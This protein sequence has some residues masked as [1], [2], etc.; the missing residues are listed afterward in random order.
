MVYNWGSDVFIKG[1]Y[2]ISITDQAGN[3]LPG[4]M[5]Y[6][7]VGTCTSDGDHEVDPISV[8]F[9]STEMQCLL[10]HTLYLVV[11]YNPTS[12]SYLNIAV[13]HLT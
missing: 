10:V 2:K 1:F 6:A 5:K 13:Q 7:H 9:N 3:I 11:S 4:Q 8:H 12:R